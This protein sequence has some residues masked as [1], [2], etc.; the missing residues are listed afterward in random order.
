MQQLREPKRTAEM[1]EQQRDAVTGMAA[2]LDSHIQ[3]CKPVW[4]LNAIERIEDTELRGMLLAQEPVDGWNRQLWLMGDG[5]L[6]ETRPSES[7]PDEVTMERVTCEEASLRFN[8]VNAV[9]T[10]C[11]TIEARA[12]SAAAQLQQLRAMQGEAT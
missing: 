8:V 9:E 12:K 1:A 11:R 10:L 2:Y 4:K 7:N 3:A 6:L 5:G